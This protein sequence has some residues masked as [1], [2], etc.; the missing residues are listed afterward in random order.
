MILQLAARNLRRGAWRTA[1]AAA[2][3]TL[4]TTLLVVTLALIDGLFAGMVQGITRRG[5]GDA[6]VVGSKPAPG[7]RGPEPI[8]GAAALGGALRRLPQIAAVAPRLRVQGVLIA[9]ERRAVAE[10]VG[11]DPAAEALVTDVQRLSVTGG[12]HLDAGGNGVLL[13]ELLARRLGVNAGDGVT[14]VT[15]AG[16]GLPIA[17]HFGVAGLVAT[18][19]PRRDAT[20]A[21]AGIDRIGALTGLSG[22]AHEIGLAL[23][24]TAEARRRAAAITAALPL[25]AGL[26]ALPWQARFPALAEAV[27]FSRASSWWLILL[28]HAAA[29]LVTLIVLVL[30]AHER[31]YEHAVCLAL[32]APAPLLRRVIAAEALLLGAAGVAAGSLLGAAIA[33]PL[34]TYGVDISRFVGPVGYAGGT[35]LPV[36]HAALRADDLLRAGAAL[37]A[38]CALAAWL[39]GKRIARLEP[40]RVIAGRDAA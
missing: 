19:D 29:G 11:I 10:V 4:A 31:R 13:G 27:R 1:L 3:L 33:L 8:P 22:S 6:I 21:L 37:L 17:E 26:V 35:I 30:G 12:Q 40:A 20:F 32:G 24:P 2:A 23:V 7:T 38:V 9:G 18:G 14:L 28:F 25:E 36:L 16:D 15:R 34:S 5:D 39:A